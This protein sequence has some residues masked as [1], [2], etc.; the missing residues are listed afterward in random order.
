MR[1]VLARTACQNTV[2]PYHLLHLGAAPALTS[3]GRAR[4]YRRPTAV[5]V[6]G[7]LAGLAGP[8]VP[9]GMP[10]SWPATSARK[11]R[12][13]LAAMSARRSSTSATSVAPKTPNMPRRRTVGR[14]AVGLRLVAASRHQTAE[15][16]QEDPSG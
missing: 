9:L 4:I 3:R 8:P 2:L 14:I 10:S 16:P 5:G 12:N 6:R 1:S 13:V 7:G 11:K 15:E